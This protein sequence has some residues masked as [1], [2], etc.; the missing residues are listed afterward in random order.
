MKARKP[1]P[2]TADH[3]PIYLTS[4]YVQTPSGAQGYD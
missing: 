3:T 2:A 1:D 4:T